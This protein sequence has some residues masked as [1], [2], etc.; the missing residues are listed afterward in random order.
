MFFGETDDVTIFDWLS[1][2]Q[3]DIGRDGEVIQ[4]NGRH[5]IWLAQ[6]LDVDEIPVCV[7][8]RHEEWQ[9]L[10][11]EIANA[12]STAE[13][14]DRAKRHLEHPDM[15]DVVDDLSVPDRSADPDERSADS[16]EPP[17]DRLGNRSSGSA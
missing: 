1:D 15:A 2:I 17:A 9:R 16:S 14:S 11:D 10:R 8:V 4:H 12:S 3:V 5:R 13:L 7:I 6:H